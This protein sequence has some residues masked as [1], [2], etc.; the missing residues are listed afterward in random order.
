M[1]LFKREDKFVLDSSSI[2]DGRIIQL[3]EKGY[4]EGKIIIPTLV[5]SI[6]RKLEGNKAERAFIMLRRYSTVEFL[7][8][9]GNG[10]VEEICV[11]KTATKRRAKLVTASDEVCRLAKFYPHIRIFDIRELHRALMPIFVPH[12]MISVRILKR[13]MH[14]HEGV[15]YIEGVKIIVE[16]GAKHLNQTV[17][18]RVSTM[19]TSE[20]GNLV[21]AT[22]DDRSPQEAS[23]QPGIDVS[24]TKR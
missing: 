19:L 21:F 24:N 8:D 7:T 4:F 20:T 3:F 13:G 12:K 22:I 5:R 14:S 1:L 16:N 9:R 17:N 23:C 2:I 6:V 18:A 15:G 10:M 11:L